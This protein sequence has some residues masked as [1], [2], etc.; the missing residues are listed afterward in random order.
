MIKY[1]RLTWAVHVARMEEC[2][3]TFEF[4]TGKP[5]GYRPLGWFRRRLED[6]IRI[7]VKG[8]IQGLGLFGSG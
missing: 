2:R 6:D 5:R 1:R 8:S 7:D 3:G 4:L